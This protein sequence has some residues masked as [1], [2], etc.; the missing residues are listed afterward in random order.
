MTKLNCSSIDWLLLINA[1]THSKD[2]KWW[3]KYITTTPETSGMMVTS[4][5]VTRMCKWM[6]NLNNRLN[7]T[8]NEL[9]KTTEKWYDQ[10]MYRW[11]CFSPKRAA[12]FSEVHLRWRKEVSSSFEQILHV[13]KYAFESSWFSRVRIVIGFI[14]NLRYDGKLAE[15]V[16]ERGQH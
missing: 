7:E 4:P 11:V 14:E 8:E 5:K 13:Y 1:R 9:N 6:S 12:C 3:L 10:F 16:L 15:S 2:Y